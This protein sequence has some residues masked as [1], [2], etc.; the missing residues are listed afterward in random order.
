MKFV[1]LFFVLLGAVVTISWIPLRF[2]I[3]F[4]KEGKNDFI[5]VTWQLIP[6]IWGI[7]AEIP[8]IKISSGAI[9]PAIKMIAHVEGEKG[10]HLW[11][12]EKIL[13][14]NL[15]NMKKIMAYL[16]VI[17]ENTR[18][19]R[20]LSKWL[21]SKITV[22]EFSWFTEIG[23]NE[24]ANTGMLTGILWS[25][26]PMAFAWFY[27]YVKKF[28]RPPAIGVIPNFQKQ[29]AASNVR[30]IFDVRCGHIIIG[31]IKALYIFKRK[32][33]DKF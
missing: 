1:I 23:T 8:F 3:H 32:G 21:L 25:V 24:A 10:R 22:R 14:L 26:K 19:Y 20:I 5:S 27:H 2:R 4:C 16:P 6:G 11:E 13:D 15:T 31:G 9:W 18:E 30:C 17:M 28:T 33:G 7:T 12:E 29:I